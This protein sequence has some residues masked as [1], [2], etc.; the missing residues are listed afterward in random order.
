MCNFFDKRN[1]HA[2]SVKQIKNENVLLFI[3]NFYTFNIRRAC[4]FT[5]NKRIFIQGY[6]LIRN[7]T[8]DLNA[9]Y[10]CNDHK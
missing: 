4:L 5:F 10:S 3:M 7:N 9:Y 1:E 6:E 8:E 2:L